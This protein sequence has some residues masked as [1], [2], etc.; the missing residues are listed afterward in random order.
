MVNRCQKISQ[1]RDKAFKG[2][3]K[4]Q[5]KL[6]SKLSAPSK[7]GLDGVVEDSSIASGRLNAAIKRGYPQE[8]LL[9]M[10]RQAV[11]FLLGNS[12]D[13]QGRSTLQ[14]IKSIVEERD[15]VEQLKKGM[16]CPVRKVHKTETSGHG[17]TLL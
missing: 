9:L 12:N 15:D 2:P 14:F 11:D 17:N 10:R 6:F 7:K 5:L 3:F 13:R 16:R 4:N 8:L 1:L